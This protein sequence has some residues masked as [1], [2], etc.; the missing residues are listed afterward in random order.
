MTRKKDSARTDWK[1][2]MAEDPDFMKGLVREV[3]Q[4]VLEAEMEETLGA[5]KSQRTEGRSGYR[6]G[7]YP[8][9]LITRVGQVELRVPQ[10]RQGRFRTEIF[11]R[12]QRSEKALVGALTEMYVQGVSTRKVKA[13]TEELCGHEFAASTI[14]RLNQT[15]DGELEKFA[16]RRLEEEYPYVILDARYEKVR[17]DGVIRSRAVLIAIGVNWDGRR[18][19]LAVDLANRESTSSWKEF[20]EKI[21]QR[22]LRGVEFAV[23]DDHP[24]LKRAIAEVLP[25][26]AW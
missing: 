2:V 25:E 22:G 19:V 23:S 4:Q 14:S 8:R 12:Y 5:E 24:G 13:I 18:C 26:A 16:T 1:A 15:L 6:S 17:E 11:E 9:N 3:L 7:Y 21:R 10:D 20:L